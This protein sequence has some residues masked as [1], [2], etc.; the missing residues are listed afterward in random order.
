MEGN[1]SSCPSTVPIRRRPPENPSHEAPDEFRR[2]EDGCLF[3]VCM[4]GAAFD[5]VHSTEE[6]TRSAERP[7]HCEHRARELVELRAA[8]VGRAVPSDDAEF[9]VFTEVF[10]LC[11]L[12]AA[13]MRRKVAALTTEL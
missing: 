4:V 12:H 11:S 9:P 5:F 6:E 3:P 1:A 13:R 2:P 10:N 7:G 8:P